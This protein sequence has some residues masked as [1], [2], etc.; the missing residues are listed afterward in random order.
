MNPHFFG[1]RHDFFKYDLI[2]WVMN[3]LRDD[4]FSFTFVPMMTKNHQPA[5]NGGAGMNN[6]KLWEHFNGLFGDGATERYLEGVREY[7]VSEG[8]RTE[9]VPGSGPGFRFTHSSRR[10]YF[11]SVIAALPGNSLIFFDPDTGLK[12]KGATEKHLSYSELLDFFTA[13]DEQSV[14]MVYQHHNRYKKKNENFSEAVAAEVE[15]RIGIRP[16]CID[17]NTIMFLFL[18]KSP[19]LKEKLSGSLNQYGKKYDGSLKFN[20]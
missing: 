1:D 10:E 20:L 14:I 16:L 9:I 2:A 8:I 19:R 5:K 17:D 4:L 3:E 13:M 18:V 15:K 11:N 12:K 7:F 6:M